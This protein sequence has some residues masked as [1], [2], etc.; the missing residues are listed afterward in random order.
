MAEFINQVA[1]GIIQN[2]DSKDKKT[3]G[4]SPAAPSY[5]PSI[6]TVFTGRSQCASRISK[7]RCSSRAYVS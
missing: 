5:F 3:S 2:F 7:R 1:D 6:S 4:L